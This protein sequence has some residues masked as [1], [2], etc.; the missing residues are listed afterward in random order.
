MGPYLPNMDLGTFNNK[1][2]DCHK[3]TGNFK[4]LTRHARFVILLSY[5]LLSGS[6]CL[7]RGM[8]FVMDPPIESDMGPG[9]CLVGELVY[10]ISHPGVVP[11]LFEGRDKASQWLDGLALQEEDRSSSSEFVNILFTVVLWSAMAPPLQLILLAH[12]CLTVSDI[13]DCYTITMSPATNPAQL[14][15]CAL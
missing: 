10:T 9:Y 11:S 13:I 4:N 8:Y 6:R 14:R 5:P 15:K 3:D 12:I 1:D 2:M 7:R